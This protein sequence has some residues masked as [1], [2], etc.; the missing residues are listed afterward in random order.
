M[1]LKALV[2]ENVRG[3]FNE[4]TDDFNEFVRSWRYEVEDFRPRIA[5]L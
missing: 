1:I 4:L 5:V 3:D 2:R